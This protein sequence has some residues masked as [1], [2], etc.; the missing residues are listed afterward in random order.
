MAYQG[1]KNREEIFA[2]I[3]KEFPFEPKPDA[4][5]LTNQ[6][7]RDCICRYI[8]EHMAAYSDPVLP[9]D[10]VR[11][12]QSELANLSSKGMSWLLPN[13]LRRAV[14]SENRFDTI[15]D[16]LIFDLESH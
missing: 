13:L 1:Y 14:L 2:M 15:T 4:Y 11:Y 7:Q 12:L 16:V 3:E 9:A 10:G 8:V 6:D 5:Q